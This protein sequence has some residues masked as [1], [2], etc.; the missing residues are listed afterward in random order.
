VKKK[1]QD[2]LWKLRLNLTRQNYFFWIDCVI[3]STG[4]TLQQSSA[5]SPTAGMAFEEGMGIIK[6]QNFDFMKKKNLD[7]LIE[8]M[9]S[10]NLATYSDVLFYTERFGRNTSRLISAEEQRQFMNDLREG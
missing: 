3:L 4:Y 2:N 6:D 10:G 8:L 7:F 1:K 9:K 5:L